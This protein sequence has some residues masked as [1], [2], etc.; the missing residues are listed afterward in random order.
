MIYI[1]FHTDYEELNYK[2]YTFEGEQTIE[3]MLSTFIKDNPKFF[4]CLKPEEYTFYNRTKILNKKDNIKK[5]LKNIFKVN[6][7]N[8]IKVVEVNPLIKRTPKPYTFI[9]FENYNWYYRYLHKKLSEFFDENYSNLNYDDSYKNNFINFINSMDIREKKE[10]I[11]SIKNIYSGTAKEFIR[12][13]T[14]D[15][16]LCYYLNKWLQNCDMDEF[17]KIKYFVGPFSYSLYKY[18]YNDSKIKV[19][20]SKRFYRKMTLNLEDFENYKINVGEL[21]CFPYF[22]STTEND[23]T[24]FISMPEIINHQN[25]IKSNYIYIILI[26]DYKCNNSSYPTPC[27]NASYDSIYY[28]EKEYIFP[29]FSFF[30]VENIESRSGRNND[31][32]FIYLSVPNKRILIEF[33]IKNDKTINYDKNLNELY[34][35]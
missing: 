32:H 25:E 10:I 5:K 20:Y 33:A 17:E 6:I 24:K 11:E 34:S 13:Y 27:I 29:P 8:I 26:I 31:P 19:N 3:S 23:L 18:A 35:S 9:K 16:P 4:S 7:N 28:Q 15:T 21:I 1:K 22:T 12:A 2:V 30:R 14:G